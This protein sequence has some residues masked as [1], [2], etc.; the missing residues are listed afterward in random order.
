MRALWLARNLLIFM[1]FRDGAAWRMVGQAH[2]EGCFH[3]CSRGGYHP[4]ILGLTQISETG[5]SQFFLWF[6]FLGIWVCKPD[7][8]PLVSEHELL[9]RAITNSMLI[10]PGPWCNR[11]LPGWRTEGYFA[12]LKLWWGGEGWVW[13]RP[14]RAPLP[15]GWCRSPGRTRSAFGVLWHWG[16]RWKGAGCRVNSWCL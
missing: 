14:A 16:N 6:F 10:I 8:S 1:V 9:V 2:T 11:C 5:F 7:S 4:A 15:H 13:C 12:V 3:F